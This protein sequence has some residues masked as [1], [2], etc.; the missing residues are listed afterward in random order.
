MRAPLVGAAGAAASLALALACQPRPM[1]EESPLGPNAGCYVCHM[2]FVGE[3]LS[4]THA[5][6]GVAC[7]RCHGA[8]AAHANDENIG[9]TKPDVMI[10]G[11]A[12]NPFCRTC[13]PTHDVAPEKVVARWQERCAAAAACQKTPEGATCTACHGRHKI[14]RSVSGPTPAAEAP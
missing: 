8:S 1:Q 13:H 4:T 2:T 7:V 10:Q 3:E 12:I 5:K 6:A 11:K 9:A 14:A